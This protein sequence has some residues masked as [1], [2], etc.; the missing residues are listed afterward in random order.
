M[1]EYLRAGF[2]EPMVWLMGGDIPKACEQIADLHTERFAQLYRGVIRQIIDHGEE[3]GWPQIIFQPIDE[4]FEHA[5]RL[6]RASRL[7]SVLKSIPGLRTEEDGMNGRWENLTQDVYR[8]TD[9]F[10]LHDGP[11]L[12]RGS[13]DMPQWWQFYDRATRDGKTIWFY[14]IDLTGWHPEPIRFMTGF[15]LWKSRATGVIEWAYMWPVRQDDPGKVYEDPRALLY[16]FPMAPGESGGPTLAYEAARE[17]VDD[18]RYLLTLHNLVRQAKGTQREGLA[19]SIWA[20]IQA[21]LDAATF[22]GCKG[23]AGQGN[24]TGACEILPDG[25]RAVRGDHKIDNNWSLERYR[26]LRKDIASGIIRLKGT[27]QG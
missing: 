12:N 23:R 7:L 26:L 27:P 3:V 2:P 11:T 21:A 6:E 19:N 18:Y 5:Q 25:N 20:P 15:G 13:I 4:P 24:W 22:E 14:N 16:R 8:D 1:D 10:V 17:G 9:V